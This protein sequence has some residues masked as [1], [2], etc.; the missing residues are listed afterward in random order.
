V[1][2]DSKQ[3]PVLV[4]TA[5]FQ[6]GT[7]GGLFIGLGGAA[8]RAKSGGIGVEVEYHSG[9]FMTIA[10]AFG[11]IDTAVRVGPGTGPIPVSIDFELSGFPG[12]GTPVYD[13][14][15]SA[16]E[17]FSFGLAP[18]RFLTFSGVLAPAGGF[19]LARNAS[20]PCGMQRRVFGVD[21]VHV[22]TLRLSARA[23]VDSGNGIAGFRNIFGFAPQ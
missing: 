10:H 23:T 6:C 13:C 11:P 19:C 17:T 9:G 18:G 21:A 22:N 16:W 20:S 2:T 4:S 1:N 14:Y 5:Y 8:G 7:A 12:G 3:A 15:G